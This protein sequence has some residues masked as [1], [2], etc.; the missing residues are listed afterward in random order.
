MQKQEAIKQLKQELRDWM[1]SKYVVFTQANEVPDEEWNNIVL[2]VL[3]S[4]KDDFLY[5]PDEDRDWL[6]DTQPYHANFLTAL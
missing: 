5:P 1:D 3:T 2:E 6:D 4:A